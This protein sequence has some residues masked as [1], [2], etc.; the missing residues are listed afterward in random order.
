MDSVE[1]SIT[2]WLGLAEK[3][4]DGRIMRNALMNSPLVKETQAD[5]SMSL[6]ALKERLI[7]KLSSAGIEPLRENERFKKLYER[8]SRIDL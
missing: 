8:I 6:S 5:F 3:S 7:E 4:V 2:Y 1:R